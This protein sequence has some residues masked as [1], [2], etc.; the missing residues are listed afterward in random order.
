MFFFFPGAKLKD[1]V[2]DVAKIR[3]TGLI[4]ISFV[5]FTRILGLVELSEG[6]HD[7]N[8]GFLEA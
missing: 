2:Q 3:K 5:F 1:R 7:R 4:Y 8:G 6:Q